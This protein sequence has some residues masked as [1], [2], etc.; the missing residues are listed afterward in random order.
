[1][2]KIVLGIDVS[3][4]TLSL[5]LL[6]N[7][8]LYCKTVDNSDAGF[9]EILSFLSKKSVVK[10]E[11][12]LES[13]GSYSEMVSDFFVD[14]KF[15]VKVV[16]PLK[17]HSFSRA[18]LSRNKTDKADAKLIAEYGSKFDEPSYQKPNQNINELRA[19]YRCSLSLKKQAAECKNHLEHKNVMPEFVVSSWETTLKNIKSQLKDI[20]NKINEIIAASESLTEKFNNLISIPG[21]AETTAVAVLAEI[22]T[23][24]KFLTARQLAAYIGVTPRH[25]NSETSVHSRPSIAKIGNAIMRKALYLPAMAAMRYNET[26]AKFASTLK[27][28]KKLG[29]QIIIAIMRKM[30]HAIFGVLKN[31]SKF[32][33][34][35]LFKC[36]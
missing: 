11:I 18:K 2:S 27:I 10:P 21:I 32:N 9:K 30:I 8:K 6:K 1:M 24:D 31:N 33:E 25:K 20:E 4:K 34:K 16:N 19:L 15:E 12:Y 23:I 35:L 3:K 29:K 17:I 14:H 36:A 7:N 22:G 28:R 5:A 26:F 13:T